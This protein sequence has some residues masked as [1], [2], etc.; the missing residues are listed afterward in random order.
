MPINWSAYPPPEHAG[1]VQGYVRLE[2]LY[3]GAHKDVFSIT[4]GAYQMARYIVCNFPMTLSNLS[5]DLL[6]GEQPDFLAGDESDEGAI[7]ALDRLVRDNE[8]YTTLYEAAL[9][10][11]FRGDAVLKVR[12]GQRNPEIENSPEEAI[13]EELP[14]V[15]YFPETDEDNIRRVKAVNLAWLKSALRDSKQKF[16]RV[17]RHT[18]GLIENLLFELPESGGASI[19]L[20]AAKPAAFS[21]VY[22]LGEEPEETVQTKL[23]FIPVF[24]VPNFRYGSRFWGISDYQGLEPIFEALNERVSQIDEVLRKHVA[25]KLLLPPGMIDEDGKI[26]FDQMESITMGPQDQPPSYITWD[27]HLTAAFSQVDKLLEFLFILSETA[28]SVFGLDKY[29]IAES[30]RA[31]KL[32][33]IRTLAKIGRKRNYWD[34]AIRRA[35]YA[36]MLL[37][38]AHGGAKYEPVEPTIR[39]ADGLPEDM[40]EMAEIEE[41]RLKS[42]NT[43]VQSSIERLDGA[44]RVEEE[45]AR[46]G[47]EEEQA[48]VLTGAGG[49]RGEPAQVPEEG[50]GEE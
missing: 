34:R 43:S 50:A 15:I 28:P 16:I 31:L 7:E 32:R 1:R 18:P 25:P 8:I 44:D 17:E 13:I 30:G 35:L 5:A 21:D 4:P 40:V 48:L 3:M 19:E 24:H 38:Q 29:G 27:A 10:G 47:D 41:K 49:R 6:F 12:W 39:W 46:M 36:A 20:K 42:G 45:M 22:L 9:A 26:R 23:P 37:E 33:M 14:P 2:Q 11:S